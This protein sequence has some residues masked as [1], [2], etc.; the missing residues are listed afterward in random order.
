M[1]Q[2]PSLSAF[3]LFPV[4]AHCISVCL[5]WILPFILAPAAAGGTLRT[6]SPCR[7]VGMIYHSL[8]ILGRKGGRVSHLSIFFQIF[9]CFSEIHMWVRVP[10]KL[11][12]CIAN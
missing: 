11:A 10:C 6:A 4:L 8:E 1:L 7:V 12:C 9:L 2:Q 3:S 5:S